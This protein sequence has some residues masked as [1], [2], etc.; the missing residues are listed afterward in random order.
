V[1]LAKLEHDV[2]DNGWTKFQSGVGG[3]RGVPMKAAEASVGGLPLP[4][5]LKNMVTI[6]FQCTT[7][8][9]RSFIIRKASIQHK[10]SKASFVCQAS[11]Q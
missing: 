5:V 9:Y 11:S 3:P 10:R 4:K 2:L 7:K 1:L 8:Y 6:C